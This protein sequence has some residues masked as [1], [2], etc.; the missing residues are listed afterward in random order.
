MADGGKIEHLFAHPAFRFYQDSILNTDLVNR[1]LDR[2]D[3]L[4]HFAAIADPKRYVFEPLTTLEID[5]QGTLNILKAAAHKGVKVVFASTSEVYGRNPKVPWKEDDDRVLGATRINRWCYSSAKAAGEHYCF[6][7]A[8]Q[9]GLRF[10]I[11]RYFN[12]YGPRLD[13]L[14]SG[15]VIPIMLEQFLSGRPVTIHGDGRQTR[16]FAYIDDVMQGTI[17]VALSP[18]AEG[19]IFNIGSTREVSIIELATIM[20][21]V[22]GF[23]SPFRFVPH[24]DVFGERY[25]DIPRRIPDVSRIRATVGWEERTPLEE[26]LKLTID[27]YGERKRL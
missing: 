7:Y 17:D 23:T 15:R 21:E 20:K 22:G 18:E 24:K 19:G 2:C 1:E 6:A 27:Y 26:G 25:E 5:L 12:A 14:G 9:E 3:L 10:A 11:M 8:Q 16:S 13:D 4:F